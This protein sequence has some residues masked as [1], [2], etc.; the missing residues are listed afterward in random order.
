[1]EHVLRQCVIALRLGE[2]FGLQES[3]RA[4]VYYVALLAWVG[5]HADSY[6]QARW[7]GDD[8][9]AR[10]DI[11]SSDLVGMRRAHFVVR[12]LGAGKP[13]VPRTRTAV[14]FLL[15]GR[16][17]MET[18]RATHCTLAGELAQRL[19]L[20]EPVRDAL[21]QVFE[22][23]DGK[24]D[25]GRLSGR[26]IAFPVRLVQLADVVEVFHRA[27]GIEAAVAV[28]RDRSGTQFDPAVAERFCDE[29]PTLLAPLAATT[30]WDAVIDAQPGLRG[31]LSN[32]ELDAAL[33]A[34]A[35][36][37]DLKSPYTLGHSRAVA[38]LAADAART[39]GLSED[40][41]RV[42]RMAGLVH[43]FGR[44]GISNAIW[45]KREALTAGERERIR[46]HPYLT[47]RMLCASPGLA[48]L[49]ALAAQHHERLDGS[50]YPRGL[51]GNLLSPAARILAAA[52]AY[53][54]MVE[55]RPHRAARSSADSAG[56]LLAEARE[57]RF[58]G[59]VVDAVLRAAGH[60]STR[61]RERTAGMTARE[62]EVL[63]LLARGLLNK[64][65][66]QRL[67]ITT[68]TVGNHVEHVY[69]KIG[70]SSRAAASLFATE[71][72]LLALSEGDTST[73]VLPPADASQAR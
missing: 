6:E 19:G 36:F 52:D 12:H 7:F 67:G 25:L 54:A 61:R 3:E 16:D 64:E 28:A 45:D 66:A 71:H 24:G 17:A 32:E 29:A 11:Y 10:A 70:V 58:D 37:V 53:H 48:P 35:D 41:V 60:Q 38:D 20:G 49:G 43:D 69:A 31:T 39:Y 65:I 5:C 50:G 30:S 26:A 33:E 51:R 72:G 44:L 15:S 8:I 13:P 18:M 1:M 9:V 57:G 4:V 56:E 40:E 59:D 62:I 47:E 42:L 27:G 22:R 2:R 68:K 34:I 14:D 46:L 55:P 23:W 21:L 73:P 63:R